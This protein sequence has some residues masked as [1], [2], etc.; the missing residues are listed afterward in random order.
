M[1]RALSARPA[2]AWPSFQ[3]RPSTARTRLPPSL[4]MTQLP[5]TAA[6]ELGSAPT[7]S[8]EKSKTW[9]S[10]ARVALPLK[11]NA[12]AAP[13]SNPR[14]DHAVGQTVDLMGSLPLVG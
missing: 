11:A 6:K 12:A 4:A 14:R 3:R 5:T 9:P 10:A 7:V 1:A 13:P 8:C 2:A